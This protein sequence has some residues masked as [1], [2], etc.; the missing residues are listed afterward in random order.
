MICHQCEQTPAGGCK[1][2]GVCG[3]D[4][5]I[6]ILPDTI[7]FG[8]KGIAAY[9]THAAQLGYTDPFVDQVTHEA[10]HM[11]LT[12]SNFNTQ[13]YI[14]MT[15][16]VGKS[17]IRVMEPLDKAIQKGLEFLNLSRQVKIELIL[18]EADSV[19]TVKIASA[20]AT[21]S[22]VR[23]MNCLSAW[24]FPG[25]SKK[26]SPFCSGCLVSVSRIFELDLLNSFRKVY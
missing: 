2:I 11:T 21:L 3:K 7:V 16:R 24:Y 12:K 15:I 19:S 4:E 9:R 10:L 22:I 26:Q 13:E 20:L 18:P 17:A 23:L 5:N 6:A 1:V 25:L 14:D 8:L